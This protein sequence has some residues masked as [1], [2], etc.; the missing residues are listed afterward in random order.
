MFVQTA[1]IKSHGEEYLRE[2][3][4]FIRIWKIWMFPR[5]TFLALEEDDRHE[6]ALQAAITVLWSTFPHGL[7][8]LYSSKTRTER[9]NLEQ[10]PQP[11]QITNLYLILWLFSVWLLSWTRNSS[12]KKFNWSKSISLHQKVLIVM[13]QASLQ[14]SK[15]HSNAHP[16]HAVS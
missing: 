16:F 14:K 8:A 1:R 10:D 3:M 4:K 5:D 12:L 9:F 6:R 2:I 13:N 7:W 11:P 15:C